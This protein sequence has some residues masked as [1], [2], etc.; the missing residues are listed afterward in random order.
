MKKVQELE[1]ILVYLI[2]ELM[3]YNRKSLEYIF[4]VIGRS[5]YPFRSDS[6]ALVNLHIGGSYIK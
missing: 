1:I 5:G 3:L 2:G 4:F 6:C